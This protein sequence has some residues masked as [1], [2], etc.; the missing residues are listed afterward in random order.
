MFRKNRFRR[1]MN[2][3]MNQVLCYMCNKN[4][5]E[6]FGMLCP[7]CARKVGMQDEYPKQPKSRTPKYKTSHGGLIKIFEDIK[8][9]KLYLKLTPKGLAEQ[10]TNSDFTMDLI[11]DLWESEF[12]YYS[13]VMDGWDYIYSW[14]DIV[15]QLTDYR[16]N[17]FTDLLKY[18]EV[19]LDGLE[20]KEHYYFPDDEEQYEW[21]EELGLYGWEGEND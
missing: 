5:V 17:R 1:Q 6:T 19:I 11:N 15:Y 7:S 10:Q 3:R 8:K 4:P 12:R 14:S 2:F 13:S 18:G 20:S 16:F 21:I 9:Q